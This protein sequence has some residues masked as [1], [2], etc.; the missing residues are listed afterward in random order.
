M[1]TLPKLNKS[2]SSNPCS[3]NTCLAT[4]SSSVVIPCTT[5]KCNSRI[6]IDCCGFS[7]GILSNTERDIDLANLQLKY[8]C[9]KCN[10]SDNKCKLEESVSKLVSLMTENDNSLNKI[11]KIVNKQATDLN[12]TVT[13]MD[14]DGENIRLTKEK[15]DTVDTRLQRLESKL[16]NMN[17]VLEPNKVSS[18]H[19]HS[20]FTYFLSQLRKP[21]W[22]RN[23][24]SH[25][26]VKCLRHQ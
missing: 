10:D 7:R 6:H 11:L 25:N 3:A 26:K 9:N 17:N 18:D 19:S 12:N 16:D 14:E 23:P 2:A 24:Y 1:L 13:A 20:A 22:T 15:I 5:F 4:K 21:P 8:K